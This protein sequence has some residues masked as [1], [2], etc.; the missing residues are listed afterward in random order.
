MPKNPIT[1]LPLPPPLRSQLYRS[2]EKQGRK[3]TAHIVMLLQ[4]AM[5]KE[6]K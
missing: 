3:L 4:K 1:P 6:A 5:E 2:A